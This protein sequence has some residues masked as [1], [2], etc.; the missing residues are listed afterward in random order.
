MKEILKDT[1][2]SQPQLHFGMWVVVSAIWPNK[3]VVVKLASV[4]SK[5][6]GVEFPGTAPWLPPG[7]SDETIE[8]KWNCRVPK[9]TEAKEDNKSKKGKQ[10][11][12]DKEVK[13]SD[14]SNTD[15]KAIHIDLD[16]ENEPDF[17]KLNDMEL[18]ALLLT[19]NQRLN[20]ARERANAESE[21]NSKLIRRNQHLESDIQQN[22]ESNNNKLKKLYSENREL[23]VIKSK[24]FQLIENFKNRIQKQDD[25]LSNTEAKYNKFDDIKLKYDNKVVE[26][27][28][29]ISKRIDAETQLSVAQPKQ[30]DTEIELRETKSQLEDISTRLQGTKVQCSANS[31]HEDVEAKLKNTVSQLDVA[32]SKQKDAEA[33]LKVTVSQLTQAHDSERILRRQI[34]TLEDTVRGWQLASTQAAQAD[35]GILALSLHGLTTQ[36]AERFDRVENAMVELAK[37]G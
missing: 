35:T 36:L 19:T 7:L 15:S 10:E 34:M 20:Q 25:D 24:Q 23:Q 32:K 28:D 22:A 1:G 30:E 14:N 31:N 18:K 3:P 13:G 26:L 27:L 2:R 5:H 11:P 9:P 21:T 37:K 12:E 6:W 29:A 33:M 8:N 4:M 16:D 17:D